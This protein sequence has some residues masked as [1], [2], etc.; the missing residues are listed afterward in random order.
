MD[1]IEE[2]VEEG[3]V[4]EGISYSPPKG[5]WNQNDPG[6]FDLRICTTYRDLRKEGK[7]C[8]GCSEFK[9]CRVDPR[10]KMGTYSPLHN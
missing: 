1:F 6:E 4:V 10:I 7:D 5:F 9:K 3:V 8:E 2:E